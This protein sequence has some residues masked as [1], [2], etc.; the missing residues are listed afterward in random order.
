MERGREKREE[1]GEEMKREN[2]RKDM[3]QVFWDSD[4]C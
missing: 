2:N 3:D 4:L 1:K